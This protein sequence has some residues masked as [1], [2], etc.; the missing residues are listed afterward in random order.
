MQDAAAWRY[1]GGEVYNES[2]DRSFKYADVCKRLNDKFGDT[3]SFKYVCPD[4]SV[5][6][7]NLIHVSDD[8]DLEVRAGAVPHVPDL[9]AAATVALPAQQRAAGSDDVRGHGPLGTTLP[10][11]AGR[12][13]RGAGRA[14][15]WLC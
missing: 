4:D 10:G 6:P 5:D 11:V 9:S 8:G 12:G 7:E 3:V 14:A 1:V 15:F 13:G 2:I